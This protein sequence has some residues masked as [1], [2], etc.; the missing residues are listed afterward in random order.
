MNQ[1][2]PSGIPLY[3]QIAE[4]LL[5]QI[6]SGELAPGDRLPPEREFSES[7]GVTRM[8]LR[9]ALRVL[10]SQGLLV[11]KQGV[12]T[13]VADAKIERKADRL[14]PFTK[15]MQ[16]RGF[17][18]SARLILLEKR[19]ANTLVARNLQIAI[20]SPIYYCVRLRLTN[21]EPTMLERFNVP[22]ARFPDFDRHDL[23]TRSVYEILESEYGVVVSRARQSFEAVV[24]SEYEA[25]LLGIEP[26]TPLMLEE[27]IGFDQGGEPV[28]FARDLYRGDRFRFVTELA[29]RDD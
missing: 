20:S 16:S 12:G 29:L 27:R 18:A 10:E 28:E 6:Q 11:R 19:L 1:F 14:D 9:Q 5:A 15:G 26:G 3:I 22:V 17:V 25:E 24:A 7:L 4:A 8:T 2:F 23:A 21:R 13:F